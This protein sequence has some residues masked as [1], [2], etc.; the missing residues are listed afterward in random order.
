MKDYHNLNP[1]EAG[2]NWSALRDILLLTPRHFYHRHLIGNQVDPTKA[3]LMGRF[4]HA[5]LLD[6]TECRREFACAPEVPESYTGS[7]YWSSKEGKEVMADFKAVHIGYEIMQ[8]ADYDNAGA[9]TRALVEKPE[10]AN[11]LINYPGQN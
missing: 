3:M 5:Y 6:P 7:R 2:I 1:L 9:M 10:S 4:Y 8:R 11:W